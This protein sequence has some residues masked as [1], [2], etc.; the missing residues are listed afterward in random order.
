MRRQR[1]AGEVEAE[2]VGAEADAGLEEIRAEEG[3]LGGGDDGLARQE[4]DRDGRVGVGA[5]APADGVAVG[6]AVEVAAIGV[7]E[8]FDVFGVVGHHGLARG[9]EL[10]GEGGDAAEGGDGLDG[11][12]GE[13]EEFF[14]GEQ[15]GGAVGALDEGDEVGDLAG[16]VGEGGDGAGGFGVRDEGAGGD[17]DRVAHDDDEVGVA[18]FGELRGEQ[19]VLQGGEFEAPPGRCLVAG[20]DEGG[21]AVEVEI[22][23]GVEKILVLVDRQVFCVAHGDADGV[24]D[25]GHHAGAGAADAG[26]DD[27]DGAGAGRGGAGGGGGA[28]G[29]CAEVEVPAMVVAGGHWLIQKIRKIRSR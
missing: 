23:E 29:E 22:E 17:G 26:G 20:I 27:G 19:V 11:L 8:E 28:Q 10:G 21:E 25:L 9:G 12:F 4:L 24:Q 14:V 18:E 7:V 16:D 2:G 6:D 15:E 13:G 5:G 1:K 3:G